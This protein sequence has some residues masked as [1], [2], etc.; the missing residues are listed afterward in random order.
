M[1]RQEKVEETFI[2]KGRGLNELCFSWTYS[3]FS[4]WMTYE[5]VENRAN[6]QKFFFCTSNG[7]SITHAFK[8]TNEGDYQMSSLEFAEKFKEF[9][10]WLAEQS[11]EN[12]RISND[13]KKLDIDE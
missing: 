11:E 1:T 2:K 10:I 9:K 3:R 5:V 8:K 6:S 12:L 7:T 13:L 4:Y